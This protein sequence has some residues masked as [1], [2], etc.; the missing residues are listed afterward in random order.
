MSGAYASGRAPDCERERHDG[1]PTSAI[2]VGRSG[3]LRSLIRPASGAC[4]VSSAAATSH[5]PPIA[6][7]PQPAAARWSG[8]ST[9]R[10]PNRS[11][12]SDMRPR[13]VR[14][15]GFRSA[16]TTAAID[17]CSP[18]AGSMR[19]AHAPSTSDDAASTEKTTLATDECG[20]GAD[21]RPEHRAERRR[22]HRRPH[23]LP[24]PLA[25]HDRE[26]PRERARPRE[27]AAAALE[28]AR[29][30]ERPEAAGEGEAEAR[31]PDERQPDEHR[32]ARAE[33]RRRD[34]AGDPGDERAARVG[35]D[36]H[37]GPRLRQPEL[38]RE[39][40]QE[41]RQDREQHRVD[42]DEGRAQ[43]DEAAHGSEAIYAGPCD[44]PPHARRTRGRERGFDL[45]RCPGGARRPLRLRRGRGRAAR[46]RLRLPRLPHRRP[47]GGGGPRGGDV[48]EGVPH[49]A[50]LRPPPRLVPHV[51]LQ[52]RA[53]RRRSTGS[54]PSRAAAAARTRTCAEQ[55]AGVDF[56]DGLPGPLEEALRELS[57]AEREVVALRVLLD[58]DGP[59]AARVLGISQTAC[60]TRLSRALNRLE[61][62]I[63][64]VR[65]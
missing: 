63:G 61:E 18:G 17:G 8:A 60:S 55:A 46:R 38:V 41:R 36:E 54:A 28:E 29:R 15:V 1:A 47:L 31:E 23:H 59:S 25:G 42:E 5:T 52:D 51:A 4:T 26:Q 6:A 49:L 22:A 27:A 24:A 32:P 10:M 58:L 65:E 62:R 35:G 57:P 34:P 2:R 44:D 45:A 16:R 21:D 40:R 12:P 39:V 11:E 43:E 33:P 14:N 50:P 64:D 13:P 7:A 30:E 9:P 48:R 56:G 3:P 37:A 19:S 53:Q 20:R